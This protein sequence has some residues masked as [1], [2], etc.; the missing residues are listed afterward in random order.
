MPV[1]LTPGQVYIS[2]SAVGSAGRFRQRRLL[3]ASPLPDLPRVLDGAKPSKHTS[4]YAS[5]SNTSSGTT[6]SH[7]SQR[8]PSWY[9]GSDFSRLHA[10]MAKTVADVQLMPSGASKLPAS[11]PTTVPLL[12]SSSQRSDPARTCNRS[13]GDREAMARCT[14]W[15]VGLY[16]AK[17][18]NTSRR[19]SRR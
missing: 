1:A 10:T 3:E 15:L 16:P 17:L 5:C 4:P 13:L 12:S 2:G 9:S 6:T 14:A 18:R 7:S 11:C 8:R 19:L